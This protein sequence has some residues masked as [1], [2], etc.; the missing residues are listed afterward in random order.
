MIFNGSGY[1]VK[2]PF[3]PHTDFIPDNY[4]VAEKRLTSLRE[5]LT[6]DSNLLFEYDRIINDYLSMDIIEKVPLNQNIEPGTIHYLPHR[7][8]I[9]SE[10]ETTKIRVVF[11]ASSK[12][13]DEP[14]LNDLLYTGPCL[15]PKLSEILLCFRCGKIALVA[16][17]KQAFL[18]IEVNQSHRDFL[19]FLW[20][21]SITANNPSIVGSRFTKILFGLNSSPFILEGSCKCI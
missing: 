3:R 18:Q 8:V 10:R 19:R 14:S 5:Q 2:L 9:K 13:S 1:E 6:K 17:I 21:D 15:L 12:Q 7:A 4:V 20:Y 16:D 11:D